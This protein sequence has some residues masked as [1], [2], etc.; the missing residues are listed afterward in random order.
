[1]TGRGVNG[2]A[3]CGIPHGKC[4]ELL[5]CQYAQLPG[6]QADRGVQARS[7][8]EHTHEGDMGYKGHQNRHWGV[9]QVGKL[10]RDFWQRSR[11]PAME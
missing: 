4:T 2:Y 6:K 8:W 11:G 10:R 7:Q 9:E 5:I 3:G 1:M